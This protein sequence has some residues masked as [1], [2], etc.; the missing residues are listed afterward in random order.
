MKT[1]FNHY[2]FYFISE[3]N[4]FYRFLETFQRIDFFAGE[5]ENFQSKTEWLLALL[6]FCFGNRFLVIVWRFPQAHQEKVRTFGIPLIHLN[7]RAYTFTNSA[8]SLYF[9]SNYPSYH[10]YI[11]YS[12]IFYHFFS[13][14]YYFLFF[15]FFSYIFVFNFIACR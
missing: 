8:N 9:H 3:S 14:I 15:F 5:T 2:L 11:F 12:I 6:L 1:I 10:L 4:V 7:S 13:S